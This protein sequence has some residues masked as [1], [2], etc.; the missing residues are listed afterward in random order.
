MAKKTISKR[1]REDV[2]VIILRKTTNL[3]EEARPD[4]DFRMSKNE[5]YPILN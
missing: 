3:E 4:G 1:I 2:R 5:I